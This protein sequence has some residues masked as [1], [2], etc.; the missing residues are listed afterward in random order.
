M[1]AEERLIRIEIH[2]KNG[3]TLTYT[4]ADAAAVDKELDRCQ[5]GDIPMGIY[6]SDESNSRIDISMDFIGYTERFYGTETVW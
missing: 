3:K 1:A 2:L 4:G 6:F 5:G